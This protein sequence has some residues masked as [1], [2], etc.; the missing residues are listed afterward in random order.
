MRAPNTASPGCNLQELPGKLRRMS[1][2]YFNNTSQ[3]RIAATGTSLLRRQTP[4]QV[5]GERCSRRSAIS[6]VK[7]FQLYRSSPIEDILG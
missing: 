2:Q 4:R 5:P 6:F 3:N 7:V 1:F